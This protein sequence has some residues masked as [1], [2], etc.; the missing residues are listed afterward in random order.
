MA[1]TFE[2]LKAIAEGT[3]LKFFCDQENQ[4]LLFG[5]LGKG[6]IYNLIVKLI[7][8]GEAIYLRI[9]YLAVVP[10]DHP[11]LAKA[12]LMLMEENDRVKVG[13]FCY[14]QNDGEIYLDW[15]IPLEDSTLT[16]QQLGR[17]LKSLMVLADEVGV[18]LKHLL[19]TGE[20]LPD[21][22]RIEGMLR[23]LLSGGLS[24]EAEVRLRRLFDFVTST[25]NN[26]EDEPK[27]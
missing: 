2:E 14:D 6:G 8:E 20:D 9:P 12:L 18:R 25:E 1:I 26:E 4:I 23:R 10:A 5:G 24:E 16:S 7:E 21:E 3:D 27:G 15:F 11:N 19:E 22:R 17:C 13:R